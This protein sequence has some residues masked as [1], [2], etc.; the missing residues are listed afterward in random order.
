MCG[1]ADGQALPPGAFAS[2]PGVGWNNGGPEWAE[3]HRMFVVLDCVSESSDCLY[4]RICCISDAN[5]HNAGVRPGTHQIAPPLF[6]RYLSFDIVHL[7]KN[8]SAGRSHLSNQTE[9]VCSRPDTSLRRH[10]QARERPSGHD[11]LYF[12]SPGRP[13]NLIVSPLKWLSYVFG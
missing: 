3:R 4:C 12:I 11:E 7:T 13:E 1:G 9:C 2:R 5:I 8:G 6:S 10:D